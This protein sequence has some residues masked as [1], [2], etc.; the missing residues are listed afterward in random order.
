[1]F[2][3]MLDPNV[4]EGRLAPSDS[5]P[6]DEAMSI[7]AAGADSTGNAISYALFHVLSDP[8]IFHKTIDELQ[9]AFPDATKPCDWTT[10]ESLPYLNGVVKEAQRYRFIFGSY[11]SQTLIPHSMSY[12]V[13]GRLPRVVPQEGAEFHGFYL[14]PG[15]SKGSCSRTTTKP[16]PLTLPLDDNKYEHMV[17]APKQRCI[18]KPRHFRP[19]TMDGP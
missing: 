9:K 3:Q 19:R 1:M 15:V 2:H 10:L 5:N 16:P 13:I 18:P 7:T 14:P 12:G 4:P 17:H 11:A 8:A 6:A